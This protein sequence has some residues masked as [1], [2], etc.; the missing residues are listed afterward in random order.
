MTFSRRNLPENRTINVQENSL[1]PK[2][3]NPILVVTPKYTRISAGVTALHLLCHYLNLS[4]RQAYIFYY[5]PPEVP[6][7]SLPYFIT[8]FEQP[9]YP[10]GFNCPV[11]TQATLDAYI[12]ADLFPIVIYPEVF[13]NPLGAPYFGRYILNYP[14]LLGPKYKERENFSFAYSKIL[15]D[16]VSRDYPLHPPCV[17][18]LFLPTVDLDYWV[19][20]PLGAVRKGACYY[21]GKLKAIHGCRDQDFAGRGTEILRSGLMPRGAVREIF[22]RSEVFYCYEDTAL[23][24]EAEL[25]GCRT[26]FVKNEYFPGPTLAGVEL[27]WSDK[28]EHSPLSQVAPKVSGHP[29]IRD[30]ILEHVAGAPKKIATLGAQWQEMAR[31]SKVTGVLRY[32]QELHLIYSRGGLVAAQPG[33]D[34]AMNFAFEV[35]AGRIHPVMEVLQR[36]WRALRRD[37]LSRAIHRVLRGVRQHGLTQSARILVRKIRGLPRSEAS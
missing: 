33:Q 20:P 12:A 32:P 27:G 21:A 13:D 30:V 7:R 9:E 2:P 18:T 5:P 24:I 19:P 34:A 29:E 31:A 23:A 4:G 36:T 28:F 8:K 37:G 22:Q 26:V 11:A 6:I 3:K 15:A 25:C 14:G 35:R 1:L 16:A 17:D 10:L